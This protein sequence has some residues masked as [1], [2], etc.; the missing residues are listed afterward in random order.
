MV[1]DL[2]KPIENYI[3]NYCHEKKYQ[4][5]KT[6]NDQFIRFDISNLTEV[7]KVTLYRTGSLVPGGSPKTDLHAEFQKIKEDIL[8]NPDILKEIEEQR[9]KPCHQKYNIIMD[10][11]RA[12]IKVKI[13]D[14]ECDTKELIETPSANEEYRLK[15]VRAKETVT[16][17]QYNNGTLFL[18]GKTDS[19]FNDICDFIEKIAQPSDQE[20]ISRFISGDEESLK[21][22]TV[23]YTPQLLEI[24]EANVRDKLGTSFSFLELHDKKWFVA[25]ECLKIANVPLPEFSPVVMPASK[26]FEGFAKK[27]L[28]TVGFYPSTH[29][30]TKEA[31]FSNLKEKN[32]SGRKSLISKEKYAGTFIDK[33]ANCLDMARNFIMHSD[34]STVTKVHTI[35]DATSKLNEIYRNT[36]ELF[37]YFNKPEFGGLTLSS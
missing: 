13:A 30:D 2:Y 24:A 7:T 12:E 26:A 1:G 8:N 14:F 9:S 18:T 33:L 23:A 25:A 6:E 21:K 15:I 10:E 32:Y 28:T 36:K 16:I 27:L 29:F 19:L 5:K 17:T 35:E 4:C 34:K 22:F 20:V 37:D 3:E 11:I 31:G